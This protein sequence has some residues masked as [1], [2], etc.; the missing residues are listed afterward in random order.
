MALSWCCGKEMI[1]NEE[2]NEGGFEFKFRKN[3][4]WI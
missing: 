2:Q 1:D 3:F 4:E